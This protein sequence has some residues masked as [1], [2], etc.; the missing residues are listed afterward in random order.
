MTA[1]SDDGN[2]LVGYGETNG[3]THAWLAQIPSAP[4]G[5]VLTAP[6]NNASFKAPANISLLATVTSNSN[7][8]N[9][10]AFYSSGTSLIASVTNRALCVFVD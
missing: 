9:Y 3:V 7:T 10:V 6:T 8:I 5:V 4:P 2:T 1:L